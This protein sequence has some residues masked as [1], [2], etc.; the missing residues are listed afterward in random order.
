MLVILISVQ[1]PDVTFKR[2]IV[3]T[4]KCMEENSRRGC[5]TG[6]HWDGLGKDGDFKY[7]EGG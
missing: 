2:V 7:L 4:K 1:V 3:Q 5:G 6:T